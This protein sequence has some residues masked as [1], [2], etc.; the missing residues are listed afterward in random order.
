MS[1]AP[2]VDD[3]IQQPMD[4]TMQDTDTAALDTSVAGAA[5]DL[6]APAESSSLGQSHAW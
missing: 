1:L 3:T 4:C 6:Q 5:A 2:D